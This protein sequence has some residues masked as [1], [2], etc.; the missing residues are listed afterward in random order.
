MVSVLV[1]EVG[2]EGVLAKGWR[3][4]KLLTDA[5]G[6]RGASSDFLKGRG[7]AMVE[8]RLSMIG[9]V[10]GGGMLMLALSIVAELVSA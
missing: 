10:M 1:V 8:R 7:V 9:F 2:G 6:L 4:S 3:S 5:G